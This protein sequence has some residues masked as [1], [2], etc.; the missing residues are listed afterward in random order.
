M[1]VS[2]CML[3]WSV[4]PNFVA[5]T[6]GSRKVKKAWTARV[7]QDIRVGGGVGPVVGKSKVPHTVFLPG[8]PRKRV[9]TCPP[10]LVPDYSFDH[11]QEY[12]KHRTDTDADGFAWD[13][14]T[15][16]SVRKRVKRRY[17]EVL[18][19]PPGGK[20]NDRWREYCARS[21]LELE[22]FG[23]DT[24]K[25]RQTPFKIACNDQS[26]TNFGRLPAALCLT[27]PY[28]WVRRPRNW[29]SKAPRGR[30]GKRNKTDVP[31]H[32]I[33]TGANIMAG[34]ANDS[35]A[36]C[37]RVEC[38]NTTFAAGSI[39]A[40]RSSPR[41]LLK[42]LRE[43]GKGKVKAR[44]VAFMTRSKHPAVDAANGVRTKS[45]SNWHR[46]NFLSALKHAGV[47]VEFPRGLKKLPKKKGHQ[48]RTVGG[49]TVC[50]FVEATELYRPYLM[51][52]AFENAHLYNY[53]TEKIVNS[54]F[55]GSIPIFWGDETVERY[56]NPKAYIN[57]ADFPDLFSLA[58]YVGNV[59]SNCTLQN[60]YLD[61][62]PCTHENLRN[63]L[64][65]RGE[66][67]LFDRVL[68]YPPCG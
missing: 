21:W 23:A 31:L 57:A 38:R 10:E 54:F 16:P 1:R 58:E 30:D 11:S 40:R 19:G 28:A 9:Q 8:N 43:L 26:H 25:N 3:L 36:L 5:V 65:W 2:C 44:S 7:S 27:E 53:V 56:F 51:V 32:K 62:P 42:P 67:R 24:E 60:E 41:E 52:I 48:D 45:D 35:A 20:Q 37:R 18:P 63:L 29:W 50:E 64:W 61:Q 66:D 33:S 12:G 15:S 68:P 17:Q 22:A 34:E 13:P 47:S 4:L 55:A 59:M 14:T 39:L 46:F 6:E 49:S